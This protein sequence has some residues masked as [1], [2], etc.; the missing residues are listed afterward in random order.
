MGKLCSGP[1]TLLPGW[2]IGLNGF[3]SGPKVEGGCVGVMYA[4]GPEEEE[5]EAGLCSI[6]LAVDADGSDGR[7][8]GKTDA[9]QR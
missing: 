5:E 1:G 4:M 6:G 9:D 3:I 7:V 8:N 2:D